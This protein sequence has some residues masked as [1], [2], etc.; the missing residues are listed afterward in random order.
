M[1][2]AALPAQSQLSLNA[3][4]V[5]A[6]RYALKDQHGIDRR[7][8]RHR[9]TRVVGFVARAETEVRSARNSGNACARY[10]SRA[11]SCPTR[12]V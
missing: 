3:Q 5:I 10:C 1:M 12:L 9:R 7:L 4:K 11:R 6:K 8:G 2:Q